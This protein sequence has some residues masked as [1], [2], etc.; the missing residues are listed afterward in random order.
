MIIL[1]LI[2]I[3]STVFNYDFKSLKLRFCCLETIVFW[4]LKFFRLLRNKLT[5][6]I[7]IFVDFVL[8][9]TNCINLTEKLW[10]NSICL[11]HVCKKKKEIW[12]IA[13]AVFRKSSTTKEHDR[14]CFTEKNETFIFRTT[15]VEFYEV[16]DLSR[17]H[18][19]VRTPSVHLFI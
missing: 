16:N 18:S 12:Q 11:F 10:F 4:I 5:K 3:S 17:T 1:R 6:A 13:R 7:S 19:F 15:P 9:S 2:F 8:L 14:R